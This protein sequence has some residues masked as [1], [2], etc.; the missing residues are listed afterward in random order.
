MKWKTIV[1]HPSVALF[2][3]FGIP[4]NVMWW[5]ENV[6][7]SVLSVVALMA[8]AAHVTAVGF[9]DWE[10]YRHWLLHLRAR[11]GGPRVPVAYG[12]VRERSADL[13]RLGV[14]TMRQGAV[15]RIRM[16]D[17]DDA[18]IAAFEVPNTHVLSFH[19]PDSRVFW[20]ET[21]YVVER[22]TVR[23]YESSGFVPAEKGANVF[24][25]SAS[26]APPAAIGVRVPGWLIVTL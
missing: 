4:A 22:Q 11:I 23:R 20:T 21:M 9:R 15:R 2:G 25:V 8:L 17:L 1:A 16:S 6:S 18:Q 12:F 13:K 19:D 7:M 3:A 10:P 24:H 5:M 26:R 14:E